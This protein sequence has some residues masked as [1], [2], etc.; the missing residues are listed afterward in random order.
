MKLGRN[1]KTKLVLLGLVLLLVSAVALL[2]S[3][4][5]REQRR[6]VIKETQGQATSFVNGA[7]AAIN[8]GLLGVDVLLASAD[9]LLGLSRQMVDWIDPVGASA[10]MQS[11]M[12]QNL[13]VN[14][15]TLVDAHG[16]TLASTDLVRLGETSHVPQAFIEQVISPS[17]ATL[18]V[19]SPE[20]HFDSSDT[21]LYMGRHVRLA[22]GSPV[23]VVA[24]VSVSQLRAML[25]QGASVAG[26]QATIERANGELLVEA[27]ARGQLTGKLLDPALATLESWS[28]ARE[29]PA[30]LNGAPAIVVARNLL[31]GGIFVTA[32]IPL[33]GAL[34]DWNREAWVVEA[35]ALAL[36]AAIVAGG[37][38]AFWYLSRLHAAQDNIQ[39]AQDSLTQAMESM[40]SGF[41]LLDRD[42]KLLHWNR[43]FVELHPWVADI[44]RPGLPYRDVLRATAVTVLPADRF[45]HEQWIGKR[46]AFL[47]G[48]YEPR[49]VTAPDGTHLEITER[50]TP[51]GGTVIVYQDVTR[52][53][54]A[55]A[56]VEMLAFYDTLTNLPNRRLLNDRLQQG[57]ISSLRTGRHGALLFLDLDHFKTLNDTAGHDTGDLL[58]QQVALRL[59]ACVREEDTVARLGGDE[60][61][62]MLQSLSTR[63]EEAALQAQKVGETIL[64]S[65][66]K[67]YLLNGHEYNS[68]CSVGATLFGK[69]HQDAAE[70]LKQADI[71]MYQVKNT[72]RNALCFFDPNM[73][74]N[75]TARADTERALRQALE[76]QQMQLHYQIQVA[77][78]GRP[79]GAEALLRWQRPGHGVVSPRH[80]IGLAEE[81]GLILPIGE[82]VLRTACQQLKQWEHN[83][84]ARSLQLSVNVSARQ[85]RA[86]DFVQVVR[87]IVSETGIQPNLLKLELTESMVVDNIADTI[88]TMRQLKSLGV[89]FAID[90][91]GTGYSSLAYLT[92]LPLD[93]LK[94]DQSFVRNIGYQASDSAVIDTIIGLARSLGLEVIAEGVE[95]S[96]QCT[97]LA[98]HGCERCQGFLFGYPMPIDAFE[99]SL[100]SAPRQA[101]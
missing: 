3:S 90:D 6:S 55:I 37:L 87:R 95:T 57:I 48:P 4:L 25:A 44:I 56:D 10:L 15:V 11:A 21:V 86:P 14:R 97:F 78:N 91:F 69:S 8:R 40:V 64:A 89:G 84:V 82:W 58:L 53:T 50:P 62:V 2:A 7:E 24:D 74:A 63:A 81:T 47:M 101:Y 71:A 36:M 23:A 19:S 92:Q 96:A 41:I 61:V 29:M 100:A 54:R 42:Q 18:F 35:L 38:A 27:P 77:A 1:P 45:D 28:A 88:M 68:S 30:R 49:H 43:R 59:K 34:Q 9:Q 72:G 16:K 22:D 31:Y 98:E 80:F 99:A 60:F 12:R 52:L 32:S 65:V 20:T 13:L 17:I 75:I 76:Q 5:N 85:F 26:L 79:I 67:P 33:E 93:Q 46:V 70:L 83:P 51:D 66:N 94:I 39:K 73:L